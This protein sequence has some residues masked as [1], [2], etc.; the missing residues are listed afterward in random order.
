[1]SVRDSV[2]GQ[3]PKPTLSVPQSACESQ[4]WAIATLEKR[5]QC[6]LRVMSVGLSPV[7][8]DGAPVANHREIGSRAK[9]EC[10][11]ELALVRCFPTSGSRAGG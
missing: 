11:F 9:T 1:M 2:T 3:L 8:F 6:S 7:S 5:R 10:F 4:T